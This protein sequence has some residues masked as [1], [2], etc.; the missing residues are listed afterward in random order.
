MKRPLE[1]SRLYKGLYVLNR[2]FALIVR[3]SGSR[4]IRLLAE[5]LSAQVN[6]GL[7]EALRD[8]EEKDWARFGRLRFPQTPKEGSHLKNS[9]TRRKGGK[10]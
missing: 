6:C 10:T 7:A 8:R 1:K 9:K 3:N 2:G 4:T 5:E